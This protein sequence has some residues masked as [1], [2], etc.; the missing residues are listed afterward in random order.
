M[1]IPSQEF[2][3]CGSVRMQVDEHFLDAKT[4]A[5]PQPDREHRYTPNWNQALRD[6]IR[7]RSQPRP[8]SGRQQ[9]CL[10]RLLLGARFSP[11]A[12]PDCMVGMKTHREPPRSSPSING[13]L[14][15]DCAPCISNSKVIS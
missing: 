15:I 1:N 11:L 9:K 4:L 6:C 7:D 5:Q 8:G 13:S 14:T 12:C 10:H 2:T 3:N